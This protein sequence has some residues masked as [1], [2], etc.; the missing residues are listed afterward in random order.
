MIDS[1]LFVIRSS[2]TEFPV[3]CA[4]HV[5]VGEVPGLTAPSLSELPP[6]SFPSSPVKNAERVL[7]GAKSIL[8]DPTKVPDFSSVQ[9][10]IP[11]AQISFVKSQPQQPN[12]FFA[13]Q[14]QPKTNSYQPQSQQQQQKPSS[15]WSSARPS[16]NFVKSSSPLPASS[17]SPQQQSFTFQKS[18]SPM[19]PQPAPQMF[20]PQPQSQ[21]RK[22][23]M[24][25]SS[26]SQQHISFNAP[27]SASFKRRSHP[28][29]GQDMNSVVERAIAESSNPHALNTQIRRTILENLICTG[30]S[31]AGAAEALLLFG[32]SNQPALYEY[33]EKYRRFEREGYDRM[34]IRF[35]LAKFYRDDESVK[36]CLDMFNWLHREFGTNLQE[37]Q[38]ILEFAGFNVHEARSYANGIRNIKASNPTYSLDDVVRDIKKY[39]VAKI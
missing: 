14:P 15:Q 35:I 3:C 23:Q 7:F 29:Q 18:S 4:Y 11:P 21:Q 16:V 24:P 25:Q 34:A 38:V 5:K 13:R 27:P 37:L 33:A 10:S 9:P 19:V 31:P 6:I 17:A 20:Q 36:Y 1:S 26:K 12:Q 32:E 2:Q 28:Q 30:T 39:G 8:S 22:Y